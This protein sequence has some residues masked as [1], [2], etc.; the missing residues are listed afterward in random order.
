MPPELACTGNLEFRTTRWGDVRVVVE[1]SDADG[2]VESCS[3]GDATAGVGPAFTN[4]VPPGPS[5]GVTTVDGI[6]LGDP[7]SDVG[8]NRV[9][10][11]DGSTS[12]AAGPR[13]G[14]VRRAADR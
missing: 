13:A 9:F 10:G 3:V 5:A 4:D 8:E 7:I 2:R 11:S 6:G 12:F 1:R 14:T